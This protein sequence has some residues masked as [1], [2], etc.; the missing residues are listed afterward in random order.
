MGELERHTGD[1]LADP[2]TFRFPTSVQRG[3]AEVQQITGKSEEQLVLEAGDAIVA[4]YEQSWQRDKAL[5]SDPAAG[6]ND[7]QSQAQTQK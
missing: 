6:S 7:M 4:A 2:I 3:L 5:L 1:G